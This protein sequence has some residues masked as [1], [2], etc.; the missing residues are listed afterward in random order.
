MQ[1]AGTRGDAMKSAGVIAD[2]AIW[3]PDSADDVPSMDDSRAYCKRLA[4][5]HYENFT[6]A[7]WLLPRALRQHMFNVYA[8]CRWADDLGDETGDPARSAALLAWWRRELERCFAGVVSHPVYV[9]LGE[10]IRDF[11]LDSQPFHDLISAF[12]QDQRVQEYDTFE[13][14]LDYC[15]RSANPVG[16]I[17][18]ALFRASTPQNVELSD[19][20]CTGLQLANFWQD[21]ARDH[22]NGRVY[23]PGDDRLRFAYTDDDLAHQRTTP[24]FIQLMK[25]EVDRAR[26]FLVRGRPLA[27]AVRGRLRIDVELFIGG[28]LRI[29]DEIERI[30]FRVWETR[31]EVSKSAKFSL[32]VRSVIRGSRLGLNRR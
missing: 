15:R 26:E 29:L 14:L 20:I 22:A 16:R 3:G 12:E 32:L 9:A 13:Q 19:S 6:V 2:L 4:T 24:G 31:P 1:S 17:V 30:G 5:S 23:L 28:G 11:S 10:T 21:V 8:F 7:S 18:L 25:F 27:A